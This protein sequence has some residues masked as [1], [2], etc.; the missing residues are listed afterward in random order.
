MVARYYPLCRSSNVLQSPNIV[1]SLKHCK[2]Q[3]LIFYIVICIIKLYTAKLSHITSL[4]VRKLKK[5]CK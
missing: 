1:I 5:S 4:I 3:V 2:A